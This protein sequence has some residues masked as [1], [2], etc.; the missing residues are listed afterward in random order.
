MD[1]SRRL[2]RAVNRVAGRAALA[3]VMVCSLAHAQYPERPIRFIVPQA[4]GSASDT[5]A[6][7]L[8]VEL[9]KHVG[10]AVVV[11][12]RPGGAF[13]IGMEAVAKA[14]PDG[15]TIGLGNIGA[16]AITRHMVARL[17]YDVE[18]DFQP[19]ALLA[20]GQLLLA[21]SL[22][23]P[24]NSVQELVEH[25]RKNPEK[26]LNASSGNG[27]P[28]HVAGEF[29]KLVTGTRMT[30]VPYKGGAAAINDLIAGHVNLI[31]ESMN[32]I[33]GQARGGK[34]KPLAVTGTKRSGALPEVPTM[35]E[36]GVPGY[37][38]QSWS[39]VVAPA[40]VSRAVVDRLNLAINASIASPAY[41]E[42]YASAVGEDLG[43]GTPEDFA[44]LIRRDSAKW[45]DVIR[46]SGARIE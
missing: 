8:S 24:F 40:G 36:A 9:P 32:G 14:A 38:V 21:V 44:A 15:Y 2:S 19:I 11:E 13:T 16:M 31:F 35:A 43:G 4:A 37:E 39:G 3:L 46:R 41:R 23:S 22:A 28:G 6:R 18:R 10:Q 25:A 30:H 45:A 29:F 1:H 12:N 27:S 26:L 17:P 33:G 42:R 20:R 34:V 7:L 5:L